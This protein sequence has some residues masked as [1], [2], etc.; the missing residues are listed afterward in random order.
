MNCILTP[1]FDNLIP[2]AVATSVSSVPI[3]DATLLTLQ[4]GFD[5]YRPSLIYLHGQQHGFWQ[6]NTQEEFDAYRLTIRALVRGATRG[7]VVIIVGYS[8]E[9]PLLPIVIDEMDPTADVFWIPYRRLMPSEAVQAYLARIA[10]L[11]VVDDYIAAQLLLY[12]IWRRFH[13]LE[14]YNTRFFRETLD[15]LSAVRS[16]LTVE[17][18]TIDMLSDSKEKIARAKDLYEDTAIGMTHAPV[19]AGRSM[20]PHEM[21][22]AVFAFEQGLARILSDIES[23]P[24]ETALAVAIN[25]R[26]AARV[27]RSEQILRAQIEWAE[28]AI[29]ANANAEPSLSRSAHSVLAVALSELGRIT[30]DEAPLHQAQVHYEAAASLSQSDEEVGQSMNSQANALADIARI[31]LRR[32]S[33]DP[34]GARE[35]FGKARRAF[36]RIMAHPTRNAKAI[37]NYASL[38]IDIAHQLGEPQLLGD[39]QAAA[40]KAETMQRGA[41][42]YNLACCAALAG[43]VPLTVQWLKSATR[44][45]NHRVEQIEAD[46]DFDA[47]R[48]DPRFVSFVQD[49]RSQRD[50]A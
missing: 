17:R 35:Y 12:Q 4:H 31:R 19:S 45:R 11:R 46:V 5:V 34:A 38:L 3:Y 29:Q 50:R 27:L 25:L 9:D 47:I 44:A 32:V 7:N 43:D 2:R 10:R 39:A 42:A 8:G 15:K 23:L 18:H 26:D 48:A 20:A 14:R 33:P 30:A 24:A 41:G 36:D 6:L 21:L 28:R 40:E 13:A 22:T 16:T 49:L 1:N 37:N